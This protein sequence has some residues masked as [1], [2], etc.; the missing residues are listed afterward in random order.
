MN[1]NPRDRKN[2]NLS[3]NFPFYYPR[4]TINYYRYNF[5]LRKILLPKPFKIN[6]RIVDKNLGEICLFLATNWQMREGLTHPSLKLSLTFRPPLVSMCAKLRKEVGIRA[7]G[8]YRDLR[9]KAIVKKIIYMPN[10]DTQYYSFRRAQLVVETFR[11]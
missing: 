7:G 11:H 8:E 5:F 4:N 10:V 6:R 3:F 1:K 2:W 9:D